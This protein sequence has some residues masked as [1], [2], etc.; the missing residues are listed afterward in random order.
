[1]LQISE[2]QNYMLNNIFCK[3]LYWWG[4]QVVKEL[5]KIIN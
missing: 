1:M 5:A 4:F 2:Q 3:S